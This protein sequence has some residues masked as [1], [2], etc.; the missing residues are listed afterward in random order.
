MPILRGPTISSRCNA[1]TAER[2]LQSSKL[3]KPAQDLQRGGPWLPAKRQQTWL[4]ANFDFQAV[5]RAAITAAGLYAARSL[6]GLTNADGT[7]RV[8]MPLRMALSHCSQL[9]GHTMQ[10]NITSAYVA[11]SLIR[12]VSFLV[13]WHIACSSLDIF[14]STCSVG[15]ISPRSTDNK[16]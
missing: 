12:F 5:Q 16:C 7:V 6:W 3:M 14:M 11:P 2:D 8:D 1:C 15:C 13:L 4:T 9:H 10:D